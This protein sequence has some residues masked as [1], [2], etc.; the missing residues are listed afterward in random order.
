MTFHPSSFKALCFRTTPHE[1]LIAFDKILSTLS[2][3]RACENTSE[4]GLASNKRQEAVDFLIKH[5]WGY[6]HIHYF[7]EQSTSSYLATADEF[8]RSLIHRYRQMIDEAGLL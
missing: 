7:F 5:K 2:Y 8:Q 3:H 1:E 4:M 6:D